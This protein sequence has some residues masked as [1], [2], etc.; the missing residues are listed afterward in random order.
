MNVVDSSGW[1]EYYA[2]AANAEFFA[3]AL[4]NLDELLVPGISINEVFKRVLQQRGEN[5][6]LEAAALM[7]QGQVVD[8]DSAI[9]ISSAKLSAELQLPMADSIMLTTA[10]AHNAVLWTRDADFEHIADVRYI[11]RT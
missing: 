8:L 3:R 11:A 5:E 2:D 4:E 9:A 6:A 7:M 1:L 10:R